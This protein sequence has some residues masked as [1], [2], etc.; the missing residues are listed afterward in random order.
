MWFVFLYEDVDKYGHAGISLLTKIYQLI[1]VK[2]N[3]HEL[4]FF[5]IVILS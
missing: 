2:Q 5:D 4:T 1:K 3:V